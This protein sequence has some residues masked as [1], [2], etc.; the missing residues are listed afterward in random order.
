MLSIRYDKSMIA[1]DDYKPDLLILLKLKQNAQVDFF[2]CE[3]K[4]PG[5][6]SN[7]YESDFIKI[8]REMKAMINEQI[9]LGVDSPLC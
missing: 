6:S 4:K 1:L 2:V 3:I 9:N 8:Q 5:C 7:K